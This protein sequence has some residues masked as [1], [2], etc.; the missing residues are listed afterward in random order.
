MKIHLFIELHFIIFQTDIQPLN[1]LFQSTQVQLTS[2]LFCRKVD[3][4]TNYCFHATSGNTSEILRFNVSLIKKSPSI[5]CCFECNNV[6]IYVM[7]DQLQCICIMRIVII[8]YMNVIS[9]DGNSILKWRGVPG[10]LSTFSAFWGKGRSKWICINACLF[11]VKNFPIRN[12]R[13][14]FTTSCA[15]GYD[16]QGI[17]TPTPLQSSYYHDST[18]A[19]RQSLI[20]KQ[21]SMLF[22]IFTRVKKRTIILKGQV[23]YFDRNVNVSFHTT[24]A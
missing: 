8:D 15:R 24:Q 21:G 5:C 9:Y 3:Q 7:L 6:K 22:I 1:I 10:F 12:C 18:N 2:F 4:I 17:C 11:V 23:Y 20:R 19:S 14:F 16:L 13:C